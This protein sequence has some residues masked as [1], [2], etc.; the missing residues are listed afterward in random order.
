MSIQQFPQNIIPSTVGN[1]GKY[2]TTDGALAYWGTG[3]SMTLLASGSLSGTV[4]ISNIPS[5]YKALCLRTYDMQK[6]TSAGAQNLTINNA[7]ASYNYVSFPAAATPALSWT[8]G[9]SSFSNLG[10]VSTSSGPYFSEIWFPNYATT[11]IK[12]IYSNTAGTSSA[13]TGYMTG[14]C[15]ASAALVAISSIQLG[16][17][18]TGGTYELF[19]VK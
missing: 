2:L 3:S 16:Q 18:Y 6:A 1:S 17:T 13:S 9:G 10:Y 12:Y 8:S 15:S 7:T 4:S 19:G 14:Y 5:T 11:N